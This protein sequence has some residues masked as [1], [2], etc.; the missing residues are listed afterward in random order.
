MAQ[1]ANVD[2]P[3]QQM[4]E[5]GFTLQTCLIP[6]PLITVDILPPIIIIKP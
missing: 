3:D 6:E 1:K 4:V 2:H 5:P